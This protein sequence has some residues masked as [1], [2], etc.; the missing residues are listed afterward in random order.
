MLKWL[1]NFIELKRRIDYNNILTKPN[2]LLELSDKI[3]LLQHLFWIFYFYSENEMFCARMGLFGYNEAIIDKKC[4]FWWF[5]G[6]FASLLSDYLRF[7]FHLNQQNILYN[8]YNL[9]NS[10]LNNNNKKQIETETEIEN[11]EK[12]KLQLKD[13]NTIIFNDKLALSIVSLFHSFCFIF[14]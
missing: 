11:I 2:N 5:C 7:Q 6:D 3:D 10:N 9:L 14:Y 4:N 12:I 8:K 1:N 13:F